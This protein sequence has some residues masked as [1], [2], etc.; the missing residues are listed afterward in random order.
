M[1][2]P[3]ARRKL[4]AMHPPHGVGGG[5]LLVRLRG[6]EHAHTSRDNRRRVFFDVQDGPA[7]RGDTTVDAEYP[8]CQFLA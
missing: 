1:L 2:G 4:A 6:I 3:P 7:D 5:P 8:H